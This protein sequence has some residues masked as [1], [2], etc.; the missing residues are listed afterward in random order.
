M[1]KQEHSKGIKFILF[2]SVL[3]LT[4]VFGETTFKIP[5]NDFFLIL[6]RILYFIL[7]LITSGIILTYLSKNIIWVIVTLNLIFISLLIYL[8]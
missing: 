8:K 6:Q 4:I 5:E 3:I 7:S 2:C 1:E